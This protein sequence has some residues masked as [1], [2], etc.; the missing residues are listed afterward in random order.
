MRR[1]VAPLVK[2]LIPLVVQKTAKK[3]KT[4]P[5]SLGSDFSLILCGN[6]NL[7]G[8][9]NI[10]ENFCLYV[11]SQFLSVIKFIQVII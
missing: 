7:S 2:A 3:R 9:N 1:P 4:D 10:I 11:N 8:D 5:N 6:N